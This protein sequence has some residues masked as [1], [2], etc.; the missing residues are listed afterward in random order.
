M[1]AHINYTRSHK[2]GKRIS[3]KVTT[4]GKKL[5]AERGREMEILSK[6]TP[7]KHEDRQA[8]P[9]WKSGKGGGEERGN[10]LR[11][12]AKKPV[13][14]DDERDDFNNKDFIHNKGFNCFYTNADSL[15]NKLN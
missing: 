3:E 6:R 9:Q 10:G 13:F 7:R 11:P 8:G 14:R 15:S 12:Q 5:G 2:N 1:P 4:G